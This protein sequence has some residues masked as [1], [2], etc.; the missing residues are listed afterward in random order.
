[1]SRTPEVLTSRRYTVPV[2]LA[3]T[4]IPSTLASLRPRRLI[5]VQLDG[6]HCQSN[7]VARQPSQQ[8]MIA[9]PRSCLHA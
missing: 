9:G 3:G 8:S 7:P 2:H 6:F 1:M 5:L 4:R